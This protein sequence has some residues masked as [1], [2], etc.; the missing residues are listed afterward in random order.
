MNYSLFGSWLAG[1]QNI[2]QGGGVPSGPT[3]G[4]VLLHD[5]S[6]VIGHF[7]YSCQDVTLLVLRLV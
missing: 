2:L 4:T 6:M 7:P 3:T 5:I 1:G